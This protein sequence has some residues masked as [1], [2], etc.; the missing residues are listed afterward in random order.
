LLASVLPV[1]YQAVVAVVELASMYLRLK[2]PLEF[3]ELYFA[4]D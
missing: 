1:T 2:D 3:V 4:G